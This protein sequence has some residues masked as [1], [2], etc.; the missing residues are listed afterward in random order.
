MHPVREHGSTLP[1]VRQTNNLHQ[2]GGGVPVRPEIIPDTIGQFILHIGGFSFHGLTYRSEDLAHA[3]QPEG[4]ELSRT[5]R[6]KSLDI[7]GRVHVRHVDARGAR[8]H[9][10][11][12]IPSVPSPRKTSTTSSTHDRTA[13]TTSTTTSMHDRTARRSRID[14]QRLRAL[15]ASG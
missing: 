7:L 10:P 11:P 14:D 2:L 13:R 5:E 6:P 9:S 15:V 3:G 4:L 1:Y 8:R 12:S